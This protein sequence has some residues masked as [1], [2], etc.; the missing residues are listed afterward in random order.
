MEYKAASISG[1]TDWGAVEKA[2]LRQ[3][4]WSPCPAPPAEM[5]AVL[6]ADGHLLVRLTSHALPT[7]AAVTLDDGSVWEDSCLECF[8]S[9]DGERYIN[10]EVNSNSA[11]LAGYGAGRQDRVTLKSMGVPIPRARAWVLRD[12]WLAELD[13]CPETVAALSGVQLA[14]G[15]RFTGNF[16][17]CG[18]RTPAPHYAAWSPVITPSPDFHRPEFFGTLVIV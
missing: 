3:C 13:I 9:F 2:P 10:L 16:Y 17:S 5:Q 7:R 18:D 15:T 1:K 11:L 6:S 14:R 4:A 12:H 8:L